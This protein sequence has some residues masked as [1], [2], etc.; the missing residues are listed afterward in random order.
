VLLINYVHQPADTPFRS[1]YAIYVLEGADAAY[2][3]VDEIPEVMQSRI[4]SLRAVDEGHMLA[5]ADLAECDALPETI[6]RLFADPKVAYLH[7]HYAKPG[8]YAARVD[9]V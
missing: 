6:E 3:A 2:D 7:A 8:C 5:G 9:R 1:A 4:I